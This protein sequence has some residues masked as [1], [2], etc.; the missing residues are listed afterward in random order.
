[1]TKQEFEDKYYDIQN[2]MNLSTFQKDYN[3]ALRDELTKF[4]DFLNKDFESFSQFIEID[5]AV[6][7][8]VVDEYLRSQD[9]PY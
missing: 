9:K 4:I 8:K 7:A 5:Y 6:I 3:S 1:M 2:W